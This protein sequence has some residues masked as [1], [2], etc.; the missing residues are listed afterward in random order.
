[1]TPNLVIAIIS[2]NTISDL[3]YESNISAERDC[4]HEIAFFF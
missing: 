1:M 4:E 3:V 2:P